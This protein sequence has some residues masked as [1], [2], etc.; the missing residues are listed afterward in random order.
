M[1][2]L[3]KSLLFALDPERAHHLGIAALKAMGPFARSLRPAANPLLATRVA[4]IDFESPVGLAA[5]LDKNAEAVAGLFGL[6][7]GFVEIGT[8]TPR[9]QPGNPKPRLFRLPEHEALINRLG[10]N[11]H[12]AE[13]VAQRLKAVSWRPGPVGVNLGKNKDTPLENA[14][15]DY[16]ACAK[17]LGPLGDYVVVNLSSPNTPGLRPLQEPEALEGLLRAVRETVTGKPL[18]LKIAPDL[19][20]EAI[21]TV[22]DV[23]RAC[24]VDGV[25]CTNTTIA[26]S[27]THPLAGEVGGLSGKPLRQRS[28]EVVRRAFAHGKG[29]LPIIGVGGIFTADDAWEKISAGAAL[30]Q[31]Y[32]GFIYRGPGLPASLCEELSERVTQAGLTSIAQAV[33]RNA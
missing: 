19:A 8:V 32:S 23:A 31:I 16:V 12:G 18:F 33:G 9:P 6:G 25:I 30:V 28:T 27:I 1:Y 21:D 11:N 10:F 29:A 14:A 3:A 4:G 13:V 20:D 17:V 5:G 15:S 7:F 22:V 24:G 2:Q 26:R